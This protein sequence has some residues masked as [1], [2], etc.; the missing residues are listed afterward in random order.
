M[1]RGKRI[2]SL[3]LVL[4]M[5]FTFLPVMAAANNNIDGNGVPGLTKE[6]ETSLNSLVSQIS[7]KGINVWSVMGEEATVSPSGIDHSVRVSYEIE[8]P[9]RAGYESSQD[10]VI[11]FFLNNPSGPAVSFTYTLYSGSAR[12]GE[13][14]DGASGTVTFLAGETEKEVTIDILELKNNPA[15]FGT[16]SDRDEFWKGDRFFY[17]ICGNIQNALFTGDKE[18]MTV[19]V[20]IEN[21][22]DFEQVYQNAADTYL[23]DLSAQLS[24]LSGVESF[25]ETPGKYLADGISEIS[26]TA[27]ISGGVRTMIDTG[28][29][30]HI[31]MP[32]G[33]FLNENAATGGISFRT[34]RNL[35]SGSDTIFN[36]FIA[37]GGESDIGFELGEQKIESV[38]LGSM[39]ESNGLV[40]SLD[41]VFDYSSAEGEVSTYFCDAEGNYLQ[42]QVS[43]SDQTAPFV[44]STAITADDFY[45]GDSI[46]ITVQY[47]EPVYTDNIRITVGGKTLYPLERAGTISDTVSFLYE[48]DENYGGSVTITDIIGATDLSGKA[49]QE[50]GEQVSSAALSP[51]DAQKAFAYCAEPSVTID[52]GESINAKGKI[53]V[54]LKNYMDLSNWFAVHIGESGVLPVVKAKVIGAEGDSVDIPLYAHMDGPAITELTGEFDAPANMS[55]QDNY[56]AAELYLDKNATDEFTHVYGLMEEYVIPPIIFINDATNFEIDY[57]NWPP[58]DIVFADSGSS[59]SLGYQVNVNATWQRPEDFSW[60]S[61]NESVAT[62]TSAGVIALTGEPGTVSFTLTALNAGL[63]DAFSIESR[64]LTVT[65]AQSPFLYVPVGIQNMEIIKGNDAKVYYS[66]NIAE[67]NDSYA[68]SGTETVYTYDLYEAVYV[69]SVLQKGNLIRQET[70]NATLENNILSYTVLSDCLVKTSPRGE[71]S[72]ILDVSAQDLGSGQI[73]FASANICV[74]PLPVKAVLA[75]PEKYYITD[76]LHN[77]KVTFDVENKNADTECLLT[78]MRNDGADPTFSTD[79]PADIGKEFTVEISP[80]DE[81]RLLDV[82]TVSLKA[83][84]ESDEA[85]SYDSYTL[86]VY[87][88]DALKIMVNGVAKDSL[89]MTP[90]RDLKNMD[91]FDLLMLNRKISYTD[92]ISINNKQYNWSNI[93]DKITWEVSGD[94]ISLLFNDGGV[95]RDI[96]SYSSPVFLPGAGFMLRG[97]SSGSSELTATHNLTGMTATLDVTFDTVEDKLYIFQ[98]YPQQ[99]CTV[100]YTNGDGKDK[101]AVTDVWGRF[102]VYEESGIKSDVTFQPLDSAVF[103]CGIINLSELLANQHSVNDFGLYPQNNV[104]LPSLDYKVTF[105]LY[106]EKTEEAFKDDLIIRGGVYRNGVYCPD[107]KINGKSG[108][109]DQ[110]VSADGSGSYRLSFNPVDFSDYSGRINPDDQIEYIIEVGFPG[111][112]HYT[113]FIKIDNEAIRKGKDSPVGVCLK[114]GIRKLNPS[115]I[116]NN[117]TVISESVTVDGVEHPVS[118]L[119]YMDTIPKSAVLNME[120]MIPGDYGKYYQIL[121]MDEYSGICGYASNATVTQSYPFSNTVTL[122]SST[123]IRGWLN[124]LFKY[125]M[126]PGE[127]VNIY[128]VVRSTDGRREIKLSKPVKV[129]NLTGIP[130]IDTLQ[131]GDTD[132]NDIYNDILDVS[133]SS[134]GLSFTGDDDQV[135]KALNYLKDFIVYDTS[136]G[137]EITPTEDPLV[138]KGVIRFAAGDYSRENPSGVFVA[139]DESE[140]FNFM[141]GLSDMKAMAK[142]E[143]IKKS[144]TEMEDHKNG[145][146]GYYKTYGGGAYLECEIFYDIEDQE[147]KMLLLKSDVYLGGGGGYY[148]TYNTWVGP[149]PVTAEFRTGMTAEIGLKTILDK[150]SGERAYITEL[151]PYF[152]IY[153]FGGVGFDYE[154]V[155][156]K[157]GPY[158]ILSHDQRYLWFNYK[159]VQK[160]GQQLTISGS[161]GV[162]FTAKLTFIEYNKKY[163]IASASKSWTYNDFNKINSIYDSGSFKLLLKELDGGYSEVV[164]EPVGETAAVED[165]SYLDAFERKWSVSSSPSFSAFS[166]LSALS[167]GDGI[168]VLQSN[169]YPY[170]NP[171]L[172]GDGKIMVY[173]S[174][175]DSADIADTAVCFTTRDAASGSFPEG[176]EIAPSE[177]PD[178]DVSVDGTGDSA[179][180]VWTRVFSDFSV[181]TGGEAT[182]EDVLN[183]LSGTEVMASVYDGT[184]F[185]TTRLTTNSTPDMAPVVAVSGD[186]AIA[187]WRSVYASDMEKP[188]DFG[189]RDNIMYSVFD[190]GSWSE[191]KCLYDGSIDHVNA[192]NAAMLSDGTSAITYQITEKDS[193]N[194]EVVCAVLDENGDISSSIRLTNNEVKDENPQITSAVFPD[195]VERFVIGWNA[196]KTS[197]ETESNVIR[198]SAVNGSGALYPQFEREIEDT[199]GGS[200]YGSFQFVKGADTM[201]DLSIVWTEPDLT[202]SSGADGAY[203]DIV[204]GMKF[205]RENDGSITESGKHKLLES[206][207]NNTVDFFDSCIDPETKEINL[208]LLLSEQSEKGTQSKLAIAKSGY[209]N[210][211][212]VNEPYFSYSD[213]LPGLDIPVLFHLY[214]DGVEPITGVTIDLAGTSHLFGEDVI[215]P[216]E[217]K[218]FTVFYKVPETV[219]NPDY[220]IT[221]QFETSSDTEIGTLK[222]DVPDVGIYQTDVTKEAERERQFRVL[223]CNNA[224]ANLEEGRHEVRLEVYDSPNFESAP[225]AVETISDAESLGRLNDGLLP[226]DITLSGEALN[227]ILDD[228]GEIPENG[229]WIY[230]NVVTEEDGAVIEDAD[231]SN[232]MNYVKVHSLLS[233][234]GVPVSIA[235]M[236]ESEDGQ[237]VVWVEALNNSMNG[238]TGGNIIIALK[239]Q[240]GKIL[241]TKQT[242]NPVDA[243]GSLVTMGGEETCAASFQFNLTGASADVV[244]SKVA[245]DSTL[246]SVLKLS[247]V[248]LD[249]D[250]NVHQYD[251]EVTDL[252]ETSITAAAENP[253]SIVT[254]LRNGVPVSASEP[255]SLTYGANTFEITVTTG[256]NE[257]TYTVNVLNVGGGDNDNSSEQGTTSSYN[258][259]IT[260]GDG[261]RTITILTDKGRAMVNLGELANEIFAGNEN[262]AITLPS[263][264]GVSSYTLQM[265]AASL[266]G[267]YGKAS[268][269]VNTDVGSVLIRGGMLSGM[270]DLDGKTADITIAAGDKSGLPDD[271]RAALGDRPI[272]QL[273]LTL[274]RRTDRLE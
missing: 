105:E 33:Y 223:L 45:F 40:Q 82:Y 46:P 256:A 35:S 221:A 10:A 258:V 206:D 160:N 185:T 121:L 116:Q 71:Y 4:F 24:S 12:Y 261:S 239:D 96:G 8:T 130:E 70:L 198:L 157:V 75:I 84:N 192:L 241:E 126:K 37:V 253:D 159:D 54:S 151:H 273:T 98:T 85:F 225:L 149:V 189:G 142:G 250:Q 194:S 136:M 153:G 165:R 31:N 36:K 247:G 242:Y 27:E 203:K 22:F 59:L 219:E 240:N 131:S 89:T 26:M 80:V 227:G 67:R 230:F 259:S 155:A 244:F 62:I 112:S 173:L 143:F 64:T 248:P 214:N 93:A 188:V 97:N 170:T 83:K 249:F 164:L 137:L 163:E 134:G 169:A 109:A 28:V 181:V 87:N 133:S 115:S 13:H 235:S 42:N 207:E 65:E 272:V 38:G 122:R 144:K 86:Y 193:D 180:A 1:K 68:G 74:R 162:E 246:L 237:T 103:D 21:E 99:K 52:Q 66:T 216:G 270:P 101:T 23:V 263:I 178:T 202:S 191:A 132:F 73:L 152:Y 264:P 56:Y 129:Q 146:K 138:Y 120:M 88:A 57:T 5:M 7:T 167:G 182:S 145:S 184:E 81:N 141:P 63:S 3:A 43:F 254:L 41:F 47:N 238:I 168:T 252:R 140:R 154:V 16:A 233:E 2:L 94:D 95:Y 30:S 265:P 125:D 39:A 176:G 92:K 150:S 11:R 205:I 268:L 53:T 210:K 72:Y 77:F 251:L 174:D 197:G 183:M 139:G 102:A 51:F 91:S 108:S 211:L 226:V 69:D 231:I 9:C 127:K 217:Y 6:H 61:S 171:V 110:A 124:S 58:A 201:E 200:N 186:R 55:G 50:A 25:P 262:V 236:V 90:D 32:T 234:N 208:S 148:H 44:K 147:W 76:G 117:A 199:A 20:P 100:I 257:V 179:V 271:V 245:P 166:A 220:N 156:L 218:D 111:S 195:G 107:A 224:Y 60:S 209:E 269:T 34:D 243:G 128:P 232:D 79:D 18:S 196:V 106:D 255:C 213:I 229:A 135:Q 119:L 274:E 190:G 187:A 260:I 177:H 14:F 172:T 114:E 104:K 161:T 19:P 113:K 118:D 15:E 78:I 222:M 48:V 175:M 204:W 123:E 49:Q 215:K 17:I 29:F 267:S 228:N 266:S 212:V 158:G